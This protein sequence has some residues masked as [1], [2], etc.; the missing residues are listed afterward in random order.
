MLVSQGTEASTAI[1]LM[2]LGGSLW[3]PVVFV[4]SIGVFFF[5]KSEIPFLI[6][7][8]ELQVAPRFV[9]KRFIQN[10]IVITFPVLLCCS[11]PFQA[12][13]RLTDFFSRA[14]NEMYVGKQMPSGL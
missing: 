2:L 1:Q 12:E 13:E 3:H 14:A 6:V 4:S 10:P 9:C 5:F 8:K 11:K 7:L